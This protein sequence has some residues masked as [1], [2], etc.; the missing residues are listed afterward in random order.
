[1]VSQ[2][3]HLVKVRDRSASAPLLLSL[4]QKG[5]STSDIV[6][7]MKGKIF[8]IVVWFMHKLLLSDRNISSW[9]ILFITA[10]N[11]YLLAKQYHV[12]SKIIYIIFIFQVNLILL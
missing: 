2:L 8:I 6:T 3:E 5:H 12:I 9:L 11:Q 1:M 10:A 4:L 7:V